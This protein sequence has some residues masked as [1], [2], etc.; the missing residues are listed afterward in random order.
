MDDDA[1]DYCEN[2]GSENGCRCC[3]RCGAERIED[4]MCCPHCHGTGSRPL[5]SG[6]EWDYLGSGYGT[7]PDCDGTGEA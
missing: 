3:E 7:C 2:C 6:I 4:C 5:L 1:F